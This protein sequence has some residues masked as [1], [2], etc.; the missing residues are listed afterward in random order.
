MVYQRIMIFGLPGS[1]KSTFAVHLARQLNLPLYHLD[2]HFF[3]EN[4]VEREKAGFLNL[5]Q[6]I[7]NKNRWIID[8]NAIGSLEMR[9]A[10]AD[11]VLYFRIS[12]PLC[13]KRL[14]QRRFFKDLS[15]QDRAEG[16]EERLR[17]SLVRYMWKFNH[18]VQPL[19]HKL[20]EAYPKTSF[21]EIRTVQ[22]LEKVF[23]LLKK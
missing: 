3:V 2:K 12:R 8:G 1:G 19:V 14:V 7:V 21:Y 15:I 4:W 22:D 23:T 9:Y 10:R 18:R 6:E 16:C 13:L 20:R 17:F 11:L 5:Q